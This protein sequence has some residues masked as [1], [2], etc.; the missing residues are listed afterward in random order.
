MRPSRAALLPAALFPGALLPGALLPA[1]LLLAAGC[2]T[3]TSLLGTDPHAASRRGT[4][5]AAADG[6]V[7]H[8]SFQD[9]PKRSADQV[10][11]VPAAAYAPID[12]FFDN[13]GYLVGDRIEIDCSFEPFRTRLVA[14][15]YEGRGDWV[16]REEGRDGDVL[17]VR[18]KN[19]VEGAAYQPEILPTGTFGSHREPPPLVDPRTGQV[20]GVAPRPVFQFVGT[21]ELVVR[22]HLNSTR[23]RPVWFRARAVGTA[24]KWRTDGPSEVRDVIYTNVNRRRRVKGTELGLSL[25]VRQ[26]PDGVW[27]AIIDDPQAPS[28]GR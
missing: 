17:W 12:Q 13:E 11:D 5:G 20:V 10:V 19:G 3:E 7:S 25:E 18:L 23:E 1:A 6:E 22:F 16:V 14:V 27:Q 2:V 15:S 24:G 4:G 8:P 28:E 9:P 26:G 21:E